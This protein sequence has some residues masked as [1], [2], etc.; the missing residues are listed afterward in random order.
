MCI[1]CNHFHF[2][3]LQRHAK[4]NDCSPLVITVLS[5]QTTKSTLMTLVNI[6]M[7]T[8]YRSTDYCLDFSFWAVWMALQLSPVEEQSSQVWQRKYARW[9]IFNLSSSLIVCTLSDVSS[10]FSSATSRCLRLLE[11]SV[12][13]KEGVGGWWSGCNKGLYGTKK[14]KQKERVHNE[15]GKK[16]VV[17]RRRGKKIIALHVS[18][19]SHRMRLDRKRSLVCLPEKKKTNNKSYMA[20][21]KELFGLAP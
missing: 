12:S 13:D 20:F 16:W 11:A 17:I 1:V 19:W 14:I 15:W 21:H 8:S 7:R 18:T 3:C 2:L 10:Y 4:H 9:L 5:K 6:M